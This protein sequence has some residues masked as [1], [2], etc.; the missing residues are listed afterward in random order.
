METFAMIAM[1]GTGTFIAFM[2]RQVNS[3]K[4][5]LK[6]A[7]NEDEKARINRRIK[8][9][10]DAITITQS[11]RDGIERLVAEDENDEGE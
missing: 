4:R 10:K 8:R 2:S 5:D 1:A 3:L 11:F 6:N 7:Q 9:R